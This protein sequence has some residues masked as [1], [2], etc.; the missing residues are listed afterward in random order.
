[1]RVKGGLRL[2]LFLFA[3]ITE[4]PNNSFREIHQRID[5]VETVI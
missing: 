1:M 3:T 5:T 2:T 4:H